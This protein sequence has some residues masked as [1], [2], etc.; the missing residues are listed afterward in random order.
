MKTVTQNA[1]RASAPV[2]AIR[3]RTIP[4]PAPPRAVAESE[5]AWATETN[6]AGAVSSQS[7]AIEF[8]ESLVNQLESRL[9]P[10]LAQDRPPAG[11]PPE[12]SGCDSAAGC[13]LAQT[14]RSHAQ[15]IGGLNARLH[16]LLSLID[17]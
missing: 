17:L 8:L 12:G 4:A 14:L 6:I 10:I 1:R 7:N 11:L 13:T 9:G 3:P 15:Y 2:T 16:G 5:V